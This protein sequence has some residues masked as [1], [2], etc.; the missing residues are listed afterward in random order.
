M[1]E[2]ESEETE[3]QIGCGRP[4]GVTRSWKVVLP[5]MLLVLM[6]LLMLLLVISESGKEMLLLMLECLLLWE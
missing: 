4:R 6:L 5:K 1:E 3:L 2:N